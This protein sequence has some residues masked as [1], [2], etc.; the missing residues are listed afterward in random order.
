MSSEIANCTAQCSKAIVR[1]RRK[2][3]WRCLS[4]MITHSAVSIETRHVPRKSQP[5]ER[6]RSASVTTRL[7]TTRI[8]RVDRCRILKKVAGPYHRGM[9]HMSPCHL[10][11]SDAISRRVTRSLELTTSSGSTPE[12]HSGL[13]I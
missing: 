1:Q 5:M 4:H 9:D 12:H 2:L 13:T 10:V 8:W 11:L 3:S 6:T 7:R